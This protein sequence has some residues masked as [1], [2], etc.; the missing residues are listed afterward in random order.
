M[1]DVL[2]KLF[3][4]LKYIL[5]IVAFGLVF[6]GIMATYARLEKPLSEAVE[7]FVPFAFV[8]VVFL[9]NIIA[10]SKTIGENL[11]FNF[12]SCLVFSV[13]ILVCLR[14]MFDK[15]ML[16]YYKYGINFNPAFFSD[17]LSLTGF[18]LYLIGAADIVLL[19]VELLNKP[20]TVK[21]KSKEISKEEK[22]AKHI[23]QEEDEDN[24]VEEVPK[25]RKRR[26]E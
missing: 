22:E 10:K 26:S 25:K 6:Y 5:L 7:V 11:L 12:V 24:D 4:F 2:S 23:S 16:L 8:L 15:N 14:S 9:I 20:K 3:S 1:K 18:I 13:I 19:L 17:N 21:A